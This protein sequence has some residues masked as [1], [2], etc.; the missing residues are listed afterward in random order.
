MRAN[1]RLY[2]PGVIAYDPTAHGVARFVPFAEIPQPADY[3][4]VAVF[5]L[6]LNECLAALGLTTEREFDRMQGGWY[7]LMGIA[8]PSRRFGFAQEFEH[9]P[10]DV[11][12]SLPVWRE[13]HLHRQ[14]FFAARAL[15]AVS[16][17]QLTLCDGP[18][19]WR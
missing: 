1:R 12:L 2:A 19:L 8:L 5:H 15:L 4:L 17:Q 6:S 11:E 14:D 7:R 3:G 10:G 9:H 18:F 16:D 13:N